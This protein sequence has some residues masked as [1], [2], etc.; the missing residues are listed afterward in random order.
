MV[1]ILPTSRRVRGCAYDGAAVEERFGPYTVFEC[2][3]AGGMATVH[4]ASI[5]LEDD[6]LREVALKRLLPQLAADKRFIDDFIREGKLAAQLKHPNIVRILE[7]GRIG[8]T[9]FIAMD[10]VRGRSL[11]SLMRKAYTK[12]M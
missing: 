3:G 5:E 9:Y 8:R 1:F 7:L 2:L 6:Q 12:R 4:R 10:L 11:M